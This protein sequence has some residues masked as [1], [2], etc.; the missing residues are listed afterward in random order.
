MSATNTTE[1]QIRQALG[2]W[3][4]AACAKDLDRIMSHYAP[5]VRA[6]D[7]ILQLQFDGAEAYR[8]HWET[9]LSYT[10]GLMIFEV[11]DLRIEAEGDLAVGHFLNRC[12]CVNEQG[13]AQ[14]SWMRGTVCYRR[15]EGAWKIVHEH[16]SA[17]FS[18][19]DGAALLNLEP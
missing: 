7:A 5:D 16:Y 12:G 8:K 9:C 1:S 4:E 11:E 18:V 19:P 13:E 3:V 10:S 2:S 15:R 6:F 14:S 17:P